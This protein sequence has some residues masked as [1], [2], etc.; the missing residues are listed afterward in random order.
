MIDKATAERVWKVVHK[1]A[2]TVHLDFLMDLARALGL[3][4]KVTVSEPK[5]K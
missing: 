5:K 3:Q 1:H 2:K 4:L